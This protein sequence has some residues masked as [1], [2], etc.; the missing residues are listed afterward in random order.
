MRAG[1]SQHV[2][3]A[4]TCKHAFVCVTYFVTLFVH[5][6]YIFK[7]VAFLGYR[8]NIRRK[9]YIGRMLLRIVLP[10]KRNRSRPKRKFMVHGE[11]DMAEVEVTE[12]DTVD[13]NNWR[14]KIR[15]VDP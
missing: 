3:A 9:G 6:G 10:Q 2:L 13:R 7:L 14:M 5:A 12:E 11:R 8:E 15:C 4:S 1:T